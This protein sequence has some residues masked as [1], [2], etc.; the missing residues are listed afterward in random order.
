[1][2]HFAGLHPFPLEATKQAL[3][4]A[5]RTVVVEGNSTGQFETLLRTRTGYSVNETMRRYDGR[6]F[7][8]EYIV[9]HIPEEV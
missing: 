5:K 2:L 1:M 3:A 4:Q 9:A 6:S 8:P 7:T